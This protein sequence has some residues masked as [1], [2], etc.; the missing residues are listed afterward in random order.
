MA[1]K[2]VL[3]T[4]DRPGIGDASISFVQQH[5]DVRWSM[6]Y[7]D[8]ATGAAPAS[9]TEVLDGN[10]IDYLFSFLSPIIIPQK[11]L[12]RVGLAINFHPGPPRWPGIGSSCYALYHGDKSFGVTA[13]IMEPRVDTGAILRVDRFPIL[14]GDSQVSLIERAEHRALTLFYDVLEE[15]ILQGSVSPS[16]ERWERSPRTRKHLAQWLT[17]S[18]D[19][20]ASE[21]A[22]KIRSSE[23]PSFPDPVLVHGGHRFSYVRGATG[24]GGA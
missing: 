20:P 10:D 21:I 5:F 11:A 12:G 15:L 7:P 4:C 24:P 16:G 22:R 1:K 8:E 3:L 2:C 23:H 13:H 18:G 19:E 17:L 6:Q 14:P 9:L